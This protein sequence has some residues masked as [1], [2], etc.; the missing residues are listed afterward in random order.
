MLTPKFRKSPAAE[1]IRRLLHT[2][3]GSL[4]IPRKGGWYVL[5]NKP[6]E[7]HGLVPRGF[8][9]AGGCRSAAADGMMLPVNT[10]TIRVSGF[11][12]GSDCL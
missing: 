1:R 9:L 5:S 4:K 11:E 2:C 3:V 7:P 6:S 10:K 12:A 8:L